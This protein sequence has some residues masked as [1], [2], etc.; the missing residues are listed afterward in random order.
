MKKSLAKPISPFGKQIKIKLLELN[1]TQS[2]LIEEIKKATGL[3]VDS[4]VMYKILI[5]TNHN[6]K[7]ISAIE[8]VLNIKET[9]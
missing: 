4:S 9:P 2:W 1:S 3:F 7:F 5:G 6:P 8:Q